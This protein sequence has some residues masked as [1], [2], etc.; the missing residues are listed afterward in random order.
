MTNTSPLPYTVDGVRL[1]TLAYNIESLSG[2]R[3]LPRTRSGDVVVPGLHGVVPST[4][5]DYES[6]ELALRMWVRDTD[7]NGNHVLTDVHRKQQ[8]DRNL[9][10]LFALFRSSPQLM[11]VRMATGRDPA[12]QFQVLANQRCDISDATTSQV[13]RTNT[14]PNPSF[15]RSTASVTVR[16]NLCQNPSF[17]TNTTGWIGVTGTLVRT[18]QYK[19]SMH[20]GN[21]SGTAL[22]TA[23]GQ[24]TTSGSAGTSTITYSRTFAP[25]AGAVHTASAMVASKQTTTGITMRLVLRWYDGA[26]VLLQTDVGPAVDVAAQGKLFGATVPV[27]QQVA[28][29][30]VCPSGTAKV[31][32]SAEVVQTT[33]PLGELYFVDGVLLEQ[34]PT[35]GDY[36]DGASGPGYTWTGTANASTSVFTEPTPADWAVNTPEAVLIQQSKF[37][38]PLYGGSVGELRLIGDP[39]P[40]EGAVMWQAGT[41]PNAT[42]SPSGQWSAGI[43]VRSDTTPCPRIRL[44]IAALDAGGAYVGYARTGSATGPEAMRTYQPTSVWTRIAL[45]G[46]YLPA[47]TVTCRLE[48]QAE[49]EMAEGV[50]VYFENASLEPN[51]ALSSYFD[52]GTPG[53]YVWDGTPD[54][55]SSSLYGAGVASWTAVNGTFQVRSLAPR[56]PIN[57]NAHGLWTTTA[58]VADGQRIFS[59]M[60]TPTNAVRSWV[61]GGF[62]WGT[63]GVSHARVRID[64]YDAANN[65]TG[66]GAGPIVA[67]S[68]SGWTWVSMAPWA[69]PAGSVKVRVRLTFY[70]SAAGGAAPV[71]S[72]CWVTGMMLSTADGEVAGSYT[73]VGSDYF[74]ETTPGTVRLSSGTIH[75][76]PQVRQAWCKTAD[77]LVPDVQG[78]GTYVARLSVVLEIPGTFWQDPVDLDWTY[79]ATKSTGTWTKEITNLQGGTG[80]IEDSVVIVYG[81]CTNPKVTDPASGAWVRLNMT[82]PAGQAWLIDSG[83]DRSA[84]GSAGLSPVAASWSN[85]RS[86]TD[87]TSPRSRLFVLHPEYD[88]TRDV[89]AVR[90]SVQNAAKARVIA[91]RKWL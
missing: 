11:D 43:S 7:E 57:T 42:A 73:P 24:L 22:D 37:V 71:N 86:F 25:V 21:Q 31:E 62:V 18:T 6:G 83:R 70:G 64:A 45:Q 19:A 13:I 51:P 38:G 78:T 55:S 15:E 88:A 77:A 52:G 65:P 1:D 29:S 80:P 10:R 39:I 14:V 46:V 3:Q 2:T 63:V 36:F 17:E 67:L 90:I 8:L 48:I 12:S 20:L 76:L 59:P 75:R 79:T 9:D 85:R 50:V 47:G 89:H 54:A 56:Y 26:S 40:P 16:T 69:A 81:P 30:G 53:G 74:D 44:R 23:S 5:D 66:T 60:V 49:D 32:L 84:V 82:V 34:S 35:L 72:V 68:S 58:A 91:R 41:R 27:F 33:R 4:Y 61:A 28:T 87:W